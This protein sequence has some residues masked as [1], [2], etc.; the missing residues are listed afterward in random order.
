MGTPDFA[1]PVLETLL[2][3]HDVVCVYSQPPR[4]AGRGHRVTK[5]PVH[6]L[7]EQ[8]GIEVR[9]PRTLK[10]AAEQTLFRDLAADIAVVAAYGLILPAAIL[11]APRLGCLNVHASLLP[12]WRGAAPI[13][14]AI[15]AGDTQSGV[16]LM[17]MDEGL[18]TGAVYVCRSTP[19][20]DGTS[21]GDLH[22]RLAQL[23]SG[24]IRDWLPKIAQGEAMA[25]PQ[26]VDGI[27]YAAKIERN[28]T[29]I[30]WQNRAAEVV[31]QI[32]AFSPS[33]GAWT[34]LGAD[35]VKV[36]A[37]EAADGRGEPGRTIADDLT[38]A[39]GQDA[40]RIERLQL[41]GRHVLSAAD[42]LIGR[43]VAAGT[44]FT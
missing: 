41:A 39:C 1:V 36:L 28:E 26:P 27:T 32:N 43:P 37:V 19:I 13:Q 12:R 11:E 42:F 44:L 9:T 35:R 14:R 25:E 31:R 33:P 22:D 16:C 24:L 18:D 2:A 3:E 10:A 5:S 38:V 17:K 4:P 23:G 29:K 40:V 7:A 20:D 15:L 30:V 8:R 21:A 6:R 34:L